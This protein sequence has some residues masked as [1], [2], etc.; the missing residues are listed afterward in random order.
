MFDFGN[1]TEDIRTEERFLSGITTAVKN[2]ARYNGIFFLDKK[3]C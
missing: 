2:E 1:M 3:N